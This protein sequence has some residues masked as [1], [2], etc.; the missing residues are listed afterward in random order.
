M[1]IVELINRSLLPAKAGTTF[2]KASGMTNF[3]NILLNYTI[4]RLP[5]VVYL[6]FK[7]SYNYPIAIKPQIM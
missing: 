2:L 4:S 5:T 6:G 1:S 3:D 7:Y